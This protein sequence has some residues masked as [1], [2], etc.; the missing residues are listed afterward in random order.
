MLERK[1]NTTL[2]RIKQSNNQQC[3]LTI[4]WHPENKLSAIQ[5]L[6]K[7]LSI[8]DLWGILLPGKYHGR[9]S[10]VGCSPWGSHR[11]GHD[12]SDLA[13]AAD[14]WGSASQVSLV[15]KNPFVN[16]GDTRDTS[17]IS[18]SGRSPGGWNS[19][20]LQYSCLENPMDRRAWW[21]T[22]NG[23]T[24]SRIDWATKHILTYTD[25]RDCIWF[26]TSLCPPGSLRCLA[27]MGLKYRQK[28]YAKNF[29]MH[30][31]GNISRD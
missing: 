16:T 8:T 14:L 13:A 19:N 10:L 28:M 5:R 29:S 3:K 15:L 23:V 18:G 30:Q 11:V 27:H 7:N 2:K 24:K 9:S 4:F 17:S 21:A 6:K 22:V 1:A 26:Y 12:W 31:W 20:L 25:G